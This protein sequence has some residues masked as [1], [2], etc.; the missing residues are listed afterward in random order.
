MKWKSYLPTKIIWMMIFII[1]FRIT[2]KIHYCT[3]EELLHLDLLKLNQTLNSS[4]ISNES[5]TEASS[6]PPPNRICRMGLAK[7]EFCM[8]DAKP[9]PVSLS[10]NLQKQII[11]SISWLWQSKTERDKMTETNLKNI[12]CFEHKAGRHCF[13]KME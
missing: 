6:S 4:S 13:L 12:E 1:I 2:S 5:S 11:T 3:S 8:E 7:E 9:S 10:D